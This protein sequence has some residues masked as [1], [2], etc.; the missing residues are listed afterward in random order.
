VSVLTS[1]EF[2]KAAKHDG[3]LVGRDA[4]FVTI[5]IKGRKMNIPRTIITEVHLPK[6]KI[7]PTDEEMHKLTK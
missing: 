3:T 4:E 2:N 1:E 7:E 5:S 6:S